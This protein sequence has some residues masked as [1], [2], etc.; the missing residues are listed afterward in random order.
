MGY[1]LIILI[2]GARR[3]YKLCL[4]DLADKI[5][6]I[7]VYLSKNSRLK[8]AILI[9]IFYP[10]IIMQNKNQHSTCYSAQTQVL[11]SD[12]SKYQSVS[13]SFFSELFFMIL[14]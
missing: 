11:M 1:K 4:L 6:I 12:M 14:A 13:L 2:S 9:H 7:T 10:I 3:P 5:I 8:T